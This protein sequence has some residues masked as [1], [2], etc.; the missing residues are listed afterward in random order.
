[1]NNEKLTK[2]ASIAEVIAAVGVVLSLIFVGLQINEGNRETRA[3]TLQAATDSEIFMQS[4]FMRNADTWEMI[5]TDA[6]LK[7]GEET[8]KAIIMYN[9]M[10]TDLENRYFQF[11]AGYFDANSWEGRLSSLRRIVA[12]PFFETWRD[13]IGAVA[14]SPRFLELVDNLKEQQQ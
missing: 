13:S 1:M 9:M 12:L 3:A 10:M 2:W 5:I 14:H 6:S 4:Q 7:N 8:R 11:E